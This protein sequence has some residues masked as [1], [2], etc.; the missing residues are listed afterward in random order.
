[1]SNAGKLLIISCSLNPGSRSAVLCAELKTCAENL[2]ATVELIDLRETPLPLCDASAA[3]GDPAVATLTRKIQAADAVVLG[4]PIYNYDVNAAAK[5]LVELTGRDAW[6][7][8]A[9]GM[10]CAAGGQGSF[11]SAMG[12][13]N[14]LMLDFR[15]VFLPRYVYATG[16]AFEKNADGSQTVKDPE[17]KA[18]LARLAGAVLALGQ[19]VKPLSLEVD[20]DD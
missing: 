12:L 6:T 18:R 7:G 13:A 2:G 19:A 20:A 1:M 3:Y 15:C 17:V 11:M 16:A 9:F 10:V 14:S 5:N 4:V 8:K